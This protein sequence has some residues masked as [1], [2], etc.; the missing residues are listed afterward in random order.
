MGKDNA[1]LFFLGKDDG[2]PTDSSN[3]VVA[4][5]SYAENLRMPKGTHYFLIERLL[6]SAM[7]TP[8]L[9]M[10]ICRFAGCSGVGFV[11]RY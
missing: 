8:P 2:F 11:L 9:I 1:L 7:G 10:L 4:S 5:S 6:V 3:F